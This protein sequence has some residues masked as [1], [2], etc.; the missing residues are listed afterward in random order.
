MA[1]YVFVLRHIFSRLNRYLLGHFQ[2]S[3]VP[4]TLN[5]TGTLRPASRSD[6]H[7]PFYL[8]VELT[9]PP[10]LLRLDGSI[11][12]P[13]ML[14]GN[15]IIPTDLFCLSVDRSS[16]KESWRQKTCCSTYN[17]YEPEGCIFSFQGSWEVFAPLTFFMGTT[18]LLLQK[19]SQKFFIKILSK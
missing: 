12:V 8:P 1:E 16:W 17:G 19:K 11:I 2:F 3:F 9:G 18:K 6:A 15:Q 7:W 13:H 14:H 10:A 4:D 5:W